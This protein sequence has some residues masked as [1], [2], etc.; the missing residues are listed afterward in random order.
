MRHALVLLLLLTSGCVWSEIVPDS[1]T[2]GAS[3]T[4]YDLFA[5]DVAPSHDFKEVR[6]GSGGEANTIGA[7]LTW[8]F[9]AEQ[10][11]PQTDWDQLERLMGVMATELARS[12]P[13]SEPPTINVNPAPVVPVIERPKPELDDLPDAVE[14]EHDALGLLEWYGQANIAVQLLIAG[15]IIAILVTL[16][17]FRRTL[18]QVLKYA[19]FWR[20]R[21]APKNGEKN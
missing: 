14:H 5:P 10:P 21:E 15:L 16:V 1:L 4:D 8:N 11:R 17:L 2:V 18:V 7:Y 6:E 3:R 13:K 19:A 20:A 12:I 9:G